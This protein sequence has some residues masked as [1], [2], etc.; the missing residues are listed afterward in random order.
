LLQGTYGPKTEYGG[1]LAPWK[2]VAML[3]LALIVVGTA[4]KAVHVAA[5]GH[6]ETALKEQF[7]AVYRQIAPDASEVQDPVR[8]VASLRARAGAGDTTPQVLLQVLER[9]GDALNKNAGARIEAISFRAGVVDVRL[10]APSVSILDGIRRTIDESG[11][12]LAKI[13][14]TDPDGERVNSR[15]QIQAMGR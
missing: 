6:Q 2:H 10:S 4:A 9:L 8:V 13:Q 14:S 3:L 5:L 11:R 1:I 12:F 7:H 15:I